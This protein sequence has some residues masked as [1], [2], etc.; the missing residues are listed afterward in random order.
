MNC[1]SSALDSKGTVPWLSG[2]WFYYCENVRLINISMRNSTG[3]GIAFFDAIGYVEIKDS[4]FENGNIHNKHSLSYGVCI[5]FSSD[6]LKEDVYEKHRRVCK[7]VFHNDSFINNNVSLVVKYPSA[8]PVYRDNETSTQFGL[9]GGLTFQF[10]D[11]D[12]WYAEKI[13]VVTNCTFKLNTAHHGGGMSL[14]FTHNTTRNSIT[15]KHCNFTNNRADFG[16]GLSV[17]ISNNPYNNCVILSRLRF[18]E[19]HAEKGGG[20]M[21]IGFYFQQVEHPE[22]NIMLL[23][24]C[25]IVANRGLYGGGTVL[26]YSRAKLATQ[27]YAIKFM[28]CLW[29][30]NIALFGSAVEASLHA[31]DKLTSGYMMSPVFRNCLFLSNYRLEEIYTDGGEDLA[32]L[33]WGKGVFLT[34][35]LPILF[36]DRTTFVGSNTSALCVSSS[37]VEFAA[38]SN[39][40]FTSNTG[41]EGGAV[42]LMGLSELHVRDNSTFIFYNNTALTKGGAIIYRSDNKL[43]FV[44]SRR[45]FIRYVGNTSIVSERSITITF[46]NNSAIG[47]YGKA[48]ACGHTIFATTLIPCW[49]ACTKGE[50]STN[51][52]CIGNVTYG[53]RSHEVSTEGAV[54]AL[55]K[56]SRMAA[57]PGKV[58]IKLHT[59]RRK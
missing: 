40:N 52:G 33:S 7:I 31:S 18:S 6:K 22:T 16:G 29:E 42:S 46:E 44:S 15:V 56:K 30:R 8:Y 59:A 5:S 26:H 4:A 39:V 48:Y 13:I 45:C 41:F 17:I 28:N 32:R 27:K 11:N 43:D 25:Q 14:N 54:F 9:G 2:V 47:S 35:A 58:C 53:N 20:G 12:L 57:I 3:T 1:G 23:E 34:T 49:R 38:G 37:I 24:N 55:L 50:Y 19:N 21:E 51:L 10:N 36:K